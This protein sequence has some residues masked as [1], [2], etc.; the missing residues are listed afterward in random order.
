MSKIIQGE[1]YYSVPE[2]AKK[3][4]ISRVTILKWAVSGQTSKGN[5]M[6]VL[7]D[8]F[9]NNYYIAEHSLAILLKQYNPE[10]RFEEVATDS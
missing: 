6:K 3:L 9:R 2:V 1:T 7:K 10:K 4:S 5:K 8:T